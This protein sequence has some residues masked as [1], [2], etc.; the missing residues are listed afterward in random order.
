MRHREN[1]AWSVVCISALPVAPAV[2]RSALPGACRCVCGE[3]ARRAQ[4]DVVVGAASCPAAARC[5]RGGQSLARPHSRPVMR[6]IE[7]TVIRCAAEG[8]YAPERSME[9]DRDWC[10]RSRLW[11][12][13]EGARHPERRPTARWLAAAG[14]KLSRCS[15]TAAF[16]APVAVTAL[17]TS[18][19]DEVARLS[20]DELTVYFSRD[21]PGGRGNFDIWIAARASTSAPLGSRGS[22]SNADRRSSSSARQETASASARR[23]TRP[24]K[25]LLST[26]WST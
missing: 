10:Q 8:S 9:M 6:S 4:R 19:R 12:R 16:G 17:N 7:T 26:S 22:P 5:D 15:P 20:P 18:S 1:V 21:R 24:S 11:Q 25:T 2:A 14:R 13:L 23:T 3:R